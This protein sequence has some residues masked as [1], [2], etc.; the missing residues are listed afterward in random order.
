MDELS[1]TAPL[2]VQNEERRSTFIGFA[3]NTGT[4]GI[5]LGDA[6][7]PVDQGPQ[8][9]R[10]S[11]PYTQGASE[12]ATRLLSRHGISVT[13]KPAKTLRPTLMRH[14]DPLELSEKPKVIYVLECSQRPVEYVGKTG[15]RLRTRMREHT[16]PSAVTRLPPKCVRP[17]RRA[18]T[19]SILE[20]SG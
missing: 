18:D 5:S 10:V 20:M 16:G 8:C 11:V 3:S 12:A 7:N 19:P 6:S 4:A 1:H 17:P 15:T 13:H 14:N 9:N 2:Q